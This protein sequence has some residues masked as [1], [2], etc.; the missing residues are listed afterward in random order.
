MKRT[1]PTPHPEV[2]AVLEA[3]LPQAR[4]ILGG[5]F[6]GMYLYGSLA[7]GGFDRDSDVDFVVVTKDELTGE[8]FASLQEMHARISQIDS[9]CATQLEGSYLPQIGLRQ[10]DP[11]R[12]L[13]Y[14]LDRGPGNRLAR[15]QLEDAR[16][17][18]AW[19]GAWVILRAVLS[20]KGIALAGP[21]LET[22]VDP[23]PLEELKRANRALL[24]DWAGVMLERPAE[25]NTRG[26]QSYVV[27]TM[28]RMLHTHQNGVLVSKPAASEW[29]RKTLEPGWLPLIEHAWAGRHDPGGE[30]HPEDVQGTLEM[31]RYTLKIIAGEGKDE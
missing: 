31:I 29:A 24:T 19:W 4:S 16:L 1:P 7:Y 23:V 3:I 11:V 13:Y 20:E 21:A 10:Y 18:R 9:W 14:H 2:N 17:S 26:Y 15:V 27:L 5:Q 22:L 6:V 8:S 25:M 28:C 12:A 30:M